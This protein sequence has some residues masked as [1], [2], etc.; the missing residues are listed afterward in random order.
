MSDNRFSL[1]LDCFTFGGPPRRIFYAV[2]LEGVFL[3]GLFSFTSEGLLDTSVV[4]RFT[5]VLTV[6]AVVTSLG[7]YLISRSAAKDS[8]SSILHTDFVPGLIAAGYLFLGELAT[9]IGFCSIPGF[10]RRRYPRPTRRSGSV[11]ASVLSSDSRFYST[12]TVTR[13]TPQM[14]TT[15]LRRPLRI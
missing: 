13:S 6:A 2:I 8:F 3:L 4:P 15:S 11:F 12:S 5:E 7:A 10:T 14:T 1:F 9:G